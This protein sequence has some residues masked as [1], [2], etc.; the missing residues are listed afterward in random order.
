MGS[1]LSLVEATLPFFCHGNRVVDGFVSF[2]FS[3]FFFAS[4]GRQ[5]DATDAADDPRAG[6][7]ADAVVV[8]L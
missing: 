4:R 2:F 3:F 6:A 1:L 5:V 8:G 7:A